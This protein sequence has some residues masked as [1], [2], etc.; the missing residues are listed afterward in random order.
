VTVEGGPDGCAHMVQEE[1]KGELDVILVG[2]ASPAQ[3]SAPSKDPHHLCPF[4]SGV[5]S[6]IQF[7]HKQH[8]QHSSPHPPWT[9]SPTLLLFYPCL[10]YTFVRTQ[11]MSSIPSPLCAIDFVPS[12]HTHTHTHTHTSVFFF[13]SCFVVALIDIQTPSSTSLALVCYPSIFFRA[14][15]S[16]AVCQMH[17][18]G[19]QT[20]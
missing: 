10:P 16:F 2:A 12:H 15:C 17:L 5:M 11:T 9:P 7:R 20:T 13:F 8:H 3:S 18:S 19:A 6:Y 14:L 4:F 1:L